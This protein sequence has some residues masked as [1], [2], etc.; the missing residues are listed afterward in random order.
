[1]AFRLRFVW[2]VDG[3][4][5]EFKS[6]GSSASFSS[7]AEAC[8]SVGVGFVDEFDSVFITLLE[9]EALDAALLSVI[10]FTF[11]EESGFSSTSLW[12][13]FFNAVFLLAFWWEV[14]GC[15]VL[16]AGS[17]LIRIDDSCLTL[18]AAV[19]LETFGRSSSTSS[20]EGNSWWLW[21]VSK[22]QMGG[23]E[24]SLLINCCFRRFGGDFNT[25]R[26]AFTLISAREV[27][28]SCSSSGSSLHFRRDLTRSSG[29][30][31][32][33]GWILKLGANNFLFARKSNVLLSTFGGDLDFSRCGRG[34]SSNI[35]DGAS[36]S[37]SSSGKSWQRI[38][39]TF[40]VLGRSL[41]VVVVV[42][43]ICSSM[44]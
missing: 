35:V 34:L 8:S 2:D 39:S 38:S 13:G 5:G 15:E 18:R 25:G 32:F 30:L 42:V 11:P 36:A 41:L 4:T 14:L 20:K 43:V 22:S 21:A 7:W 16:S 24:T 37:S 6:D 3:I 31:M 17:A 12:S 29:D 40:D 33:F 26:I 9:E 23:G 27:W 28:I 44:A 10:V 1:M 19:L